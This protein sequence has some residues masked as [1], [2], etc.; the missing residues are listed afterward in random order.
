M[1]D[2]EKLQEVFRAINEH[3]SETL[4]ADRRSDWGLLCIMLVPAAS[5][6]VFGIQLVMSAQVWGFIV[7][8]LAMAFYAGGIWRD[9]RESK[10]KLSGTPPEPGPASSF[11]PKGP[12]SI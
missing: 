11:H 1:K 5:F 4:H 8:A 6:T 12:G 2:Q 3:I 10:K 7:A 9:L